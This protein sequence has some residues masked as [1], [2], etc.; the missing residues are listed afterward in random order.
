MKSKARYKNKIM[1]ARS[2]FILS[3]FCLILLLSCKKPLHSDVEDYTAEP[4]LPEQPYDYKSSN[5]DH[6]A[7]LG[8]VLFY[9]KKMS[10]NNSISCASCHQQNKAFCDNQRFSKGLEDKFTARNSPSIFA[11][12]GRMFWDG[13]ASSVSDLV[14]KPVTN[15]VEMKIIDLETLAERLQ[16][17]SYYPEL[18]NKA[19]GSPEVTVT[20]LQFA[21]TEFVRNF[22]FSENK[23]NASQN[24]FIQLSALELQGK[25]LFNGKALC[26]NCHHVDG[27]NNGYGF[28]DE[29]H[30]IGLDMTYSDNGI[31][32]IT[33]NSEDN[34]KFMVPALL[35]I[36]F[37]APYMHDGRFQTLEEVIEHYNSGIQDHPNLDL[38]LRD[39]SD[40]QN[41]DFNQ[42]LALYDAN[43]NNELEINE[44]PYRA[45]VKLNLTSTEKK[46]L[47]A[48][49]KTLSDNTIFSDERFSDPFKKK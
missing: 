21:L 33:K 39:F 13:R 29:E 35:N 40:L 49:L 10:L 2:L 6:L 19:F 41:M 42:L 11:K 31:G 23:F 43:H 17:V 44:L 48:F 15:H 18:F 27:G 46:A 20:R 45:P 47:I 1:K 28:T 38:N 32:A 26:A 22:N 8:R 4:N 37:T 24:G 36:E 7:T 9:D 30:N 16:N 14:L 12:T 5:N 34:G 25:N 3:S